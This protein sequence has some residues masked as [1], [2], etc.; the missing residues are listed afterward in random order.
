MR[1]IGIISTA[2]YVPSFIQSNEEV[3]AHIEELSPQ[4][5]I[6]KTGIKKRHI[7]KGEEASDM[8]GA[9]AITLATDVFGGTY[10]IDL[11]IVCSSTQDYMLPPMSAK[12]HA[13]IGAS[14]DCQVIDVNTNCTGLI[15]GM[16]MAVERLKN[17]HRMRYA[18]V[19]GVELLSRYVNKIDK[20][21]APFFS[22]GASGVLIGDSRDDGEYIDSFFCTDSSAYEDVRLT[23][24][25]FIEHNGKATWTQAITNLP[26]VMKKLLARQNIMFG[27]VDF[28]IFH[29]ANKV[30]IDYIMDKNHIMPYKTY[31]NVQEIGNTGAAS[32]GIALDEAVSKKLIKP[33]MI[34]MMAGVGAGFNFGASLWKI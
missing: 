5:I 26:Y 11:I 7:A 9:V 21:T 20:F 17:N 34:V 3:C 23:R 31:T 2:S 14:K 24:G 25:G 4:W 28:F 15:T 13:L 27:D 32:V 8:A 30:L 16:T 1:S 6:E 33:G 12:I 22:D 29:Q 10:P 19:I 18:L